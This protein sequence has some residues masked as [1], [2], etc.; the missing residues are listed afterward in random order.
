MKSIERA[1]LIF[2]LLYVLM[3][4]PCKELA[5]DFTD[6][7]P[8]SSHDCCGGNAPSPSIHCSMDQSAISVSFLQVFQP[9]SAVSARIMMFG[10]LVSAIFVPGFINPGHSPPT[11]VFPLRI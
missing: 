9:V 3:P 8:F 7:C 4:C 2:G 1:I 10:P 11:S 5:Q 6:S